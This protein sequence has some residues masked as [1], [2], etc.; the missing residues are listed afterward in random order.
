MQSE[1]HAKRDRTTSYGRGQRSQLDQSIH[2]S[3]ADY[4][5]I[6]KILFANRVKITVQLTYGIW[7][8]NLATNL[9]GT[10]ERLKF[11]KFFV[12]FPRSLQEN[13][14]PVP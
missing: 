10:Q 9:Q 3:E 11:L 7:A 4:W 2:A 8:Q 6:K 1:V 14:R 12:V 13:V 5:S